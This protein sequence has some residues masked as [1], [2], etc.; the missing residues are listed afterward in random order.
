MANFRAAI[1]HKT[2]LLL[3]C[4]REYHCRGW[5]RA[6]VLVTK[7]NASVS[8]FSVINRDRYIVFMTATAENPVSQ[9]YVVIKTNYR[10][11]FSY[12]IEIFQQLKE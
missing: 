11:D 10:Q 3:I 2:L 12:T 5:R 6:A 4:F 9:K 7:R 1:K 8:S